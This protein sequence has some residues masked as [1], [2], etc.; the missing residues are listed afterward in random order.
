MKT[1][2]NLR[3][4]TIPKIKKADMIVES[5]TEMDDQ[6]DPVGTVLLALNHIATIADDL[7]SVGG[8][9]DA[10]FE[11]DEIDSILAAY[12]MLSE[13]YDK[14]E[15]IVVMPSNEY[16]TADFSE[17]V[18]QQLKELDEATTEDEDLKKQVNENKQQVK[19]EI[20][21][22]LF[23]WEESDTYEN[24]FRLEL[25][26]E[27][28]TSVTEVLKKV[29]PEIRLEQYNNEIGFDSLVERNEAADVLITFYAAVKE[30]TVPAFDL[31]KI[32]EAFDASKFRRLASTGLVADEDVAKIIVAM[33]SL[34]AGK[35]ITSKQKELI[36]NTF[37]TLIGMV[38]GDTAI[39]NKVASAAK[40]A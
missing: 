34:D 19:E 8:S 39:F 33:K 40:K 32:C 17:E 18:E 4:G 38:T 24:P 9:P 5:E 27:D 35:P 1:L 11:Q 28:T 36:A 26:G 25:I 20:S 30:Q 14:Y 37:Q 12:E 31:D 22:K 21:I 16:T 6:L 10:E 29:I 15:D 7:Y 23:K 2:K 13:I 3:E